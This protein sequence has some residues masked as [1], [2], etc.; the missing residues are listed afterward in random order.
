MRESSILKRCLLALSD[1]GILALRNNTALAWVGQAT[2]ITR[3]MVI[4]VQPGDVIVRNARPLHAGLGKGGGDI[5][6][7]HDGRF[8]MVE[9]KT[10]TGRVS[11]DQ[12]TFAAAVQAHGGLY[13]IARSPDEAVAVARGELKNI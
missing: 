8:G 3:P 5:V 11:A 9:V 2:K 13:G 4:A 12:R 6:T 7:C 10:D 1:V